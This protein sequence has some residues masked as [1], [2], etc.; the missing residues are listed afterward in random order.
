MWLDKEGHRK[1]SINGKLASVF[2][3]RDVLKWPLPFRNNIRSVWAC[4]FHA[5]SQSLAPTLDHFLALLVC[6]LQLWLLVT[7][8]HT[9][10]CVIQH[11]CSQGI[12]ISNNL[13]R[14]YNLE[15]INYFTISEFSKLTNTGVKNRILQCF[16]DFSA[17]LHGLIDVFMHKCRI[18][19]KDCVQYYF[20]FHL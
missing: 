7:L 20:L 18:E 17:L 13:L 6:L 16:I 1:R 8:L 9:C 5:L 19:E 15:K 12:L 4:S 11:K 3:C 2:Q 10:C 14:P